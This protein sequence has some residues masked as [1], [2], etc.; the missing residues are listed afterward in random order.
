MIKTVTVTDAA[1][2]FAD[3]INRVYYRNESAVLLKGGKPVAKIV[4]VETSAKTGAELATLWRGLPH[5][6]ASEA[7]LFG[8]DV[9]LARNELPKVKDKWE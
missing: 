5:L 2:G 1:R 6:S 4:P 8:D 3:L 9:S 7:K